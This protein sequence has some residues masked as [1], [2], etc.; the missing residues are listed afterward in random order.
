MP[1]HVA[2]DAQPASARS[3][4]PAMIAATYPVIETFGSTLPPVGSL[5]K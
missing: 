1:T 2:A 3:T 4:R 5:V